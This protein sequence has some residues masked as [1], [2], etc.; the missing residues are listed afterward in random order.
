MS[1]KRKIIVFM[2]SLFFIQFSLIFLFQSFTL[3]QNHISVEES[4][5]QSENSLSMLL[6]SILV[7]FIIILFAAIWVSNDAKKRGEKPGL[8]LV[9]VLLTNFI[10]IFIWLIIRP[11]YI[12]KTGNSNFGNQNF[13]GN[14]SHPNNYIDN[15]GRICTNCGR[16]IPFDAK[17]CPYCGKKFIEYL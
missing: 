16:P 2:I 7:L 15:R 14:Y 1:I 12:T 6:L 10:G 11:N 9:I 8:W 13:S 3:A 4:M 5:V 17:L